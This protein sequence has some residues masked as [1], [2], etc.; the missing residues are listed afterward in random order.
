MHTCMPGGAVTGGRNRGGACHTAIE[1]WS[2]CPGRRGRRCFWWRFF[3]L[4]RSSQHRVSLCG[5]L[6]SRF[7]RGRGRGGSVW[8]E[9]H[10]LRGRWGWG[11]L[12]LACSTGRTVLVWGGD[13]LR[14]ARA[15]GQQESAT[16]TALG[17]SGATSDDDD[18]DDD[19]DDGAVACV[20]SRAPREH[21]GALTSATDGPE[22][23]GRAAPAPAHDRRRCC[24][25]VIGA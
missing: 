17:H 16:A 9:R 5:G 7:R 8:R 22:G 3:C 21:P 4:S 10:A 19:D 23:A 14:T 12:I 24:A 1:L 2:L 13:R 18:D 25:F 15:A 6:W 20:P 11:G